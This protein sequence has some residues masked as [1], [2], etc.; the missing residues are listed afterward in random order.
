LPTAGGVA[1][2]RIARWNGSSWSALGSGLNNTVFALA[3]KPN[4]EIVAAGLFTVAGGG[5][6]NRVARWN[7][8]T[9]IPLGNGV[10]NQV[11]ALAILPNGDVVAGG[12]FTN[13]GRHD[14]HSHRPLRRQHRRLATAPRHLRRGCR[15]TRPLLL[16]M[17]D[18]SVIVGGLFRPGRRRDARLQHRPLVPRRRRHLVLHGHRPLQRGLGPE[19][20]HQRYA[21]GRRRLHIRRQRH[22]RAQPRRPLE[23]HQLAARR[24][25]HQTTASAPSPA[26]NLSRLDTIYAG[27][28]FTTAGGNTANRSPSSDASASP[29]IVIQ[30]AAT[31]EKCGSTARVFITLAA[32]APSTFPVAQG[33][34]NLANGGAV[35]GATT[36]ILTISPVA[37]ADAA[38]YDCVVTWT[39]ALFRTT[40]GAALS[41]LRCCPADFDNNGS[42]TRRSR[43]LH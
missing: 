28:E 33:G 21:H 16:A 10:D 40:S 42:I 34:I 27:G 5:A 39:G 9:W 19:G 11:N 2:S 20:P 22:H 15:H 32:P 31:A 29:T 1:A 43:Q 3:I 38:A 4:N 35:S 18:G 41:G 13:L 7:G 12:I 30:P 26:P 23:R 8:S 37:A 25:R 6:A 14:R 17:D 36:P 24:R